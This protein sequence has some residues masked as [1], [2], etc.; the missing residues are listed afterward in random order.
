MST[1]GLDENV[2]QEYIKNQEME[3]R[4]IDQLS[5]LDVK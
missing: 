4:R 2:V 3:D 1:V 5:L